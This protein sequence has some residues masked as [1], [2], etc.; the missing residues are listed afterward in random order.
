M[1]DFSDMANIS[2][3]RI[4]ISVS[5]KGKFRKRIRASMRAAYFIVYIHAVAI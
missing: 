2:E 3:I 1:I 4:P 5:S